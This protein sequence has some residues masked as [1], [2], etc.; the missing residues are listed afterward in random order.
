MLG[1]LQDVLGPPRNRVACRL[2]ES[3]R[4]VL[5]AIRL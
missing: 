5:R 3:D 4:P 1:E 2:V